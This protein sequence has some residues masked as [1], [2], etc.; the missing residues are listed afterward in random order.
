MTIPSVRIKEFND[1]PVNAKGDYLLYWMV[2]NR[3]A[4][5]NYA[6]EYAVE[7]AIKRGVPLLIF[8]GLRTSYPWSSKRCHQFVLEGMLEQQKIFQ[9][10]KVQ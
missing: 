9:K 1:R 8:E 2:S 10:H 5:Y 7:E 4:H 6:L 3:R